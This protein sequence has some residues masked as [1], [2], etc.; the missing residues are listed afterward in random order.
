M[1]T[2]ALIR[3]LREERGLTQ[4]VLALRAGTTQAAI[5]KLESGAQSP[6]V[7]RLEQVL[8]CMGLR[9]RLE[10]DPIDPWTDDSHLD[11]Y[12]ALDPAA[13]V[14]HGLA[15]SRGLTGLIGGARRA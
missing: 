6:T 12:A 4:D 9:L 15:S 14:R 1:D 7:D 10:A 13:R 11:E 5:S 2:G 8:L 3:R